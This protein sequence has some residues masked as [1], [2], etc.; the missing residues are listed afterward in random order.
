MSESKRSTHA[1]IYAREMILEALEDR[2]VLD[3]AVDRNADDYA[4]AVLVSDQ[5]L[6]QGQGEVVAVLEDYCDGNW[7]FVNG[8]WFA[9][10]NGFNLWYYD[11]LHYY[12]QDAATSRWLW[13]D[14][15]ID[16][17]WEY[18]QTWEYDSA[19][20]YWYYNDW[21]G[22]YYHQN[23]AH[24]YYHDHITGIWWQYNAYTGA[25]NPDATTQFAYGQETQYWSNGDTDLHCWLTNDGTTLLDWWIFNAGS[26][27]QWSGGALNVVLVDYTDFF[28]CVEQYTKTDVIVIEY[29][30]TNDGFA[31]VVD[32]LRILSDYYDTQ[33]SNLAVMS[34]GNSTGMYFGEWISS[35]NYNNYYNDFLELNAYMVDN[36]QI[37]LYHCQVG[38]ASTMLGK[39][40]VWTSTDVFANLGDQWYYWTWYSSPYEETDGIWN[41]N[42]YQVHLGEY[43]FEYRS[44]RYATY[45]MLFNFA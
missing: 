22:T 39:I 35:S 20:A 4:D 2:I 12:A 18:Y 1:S 33:I 42:Y 31:T 5:A 24:R 25:W 43:L 10:Q 28:E 32:G 17:Q 9:Y 3:G 23:D 16:N 7:H 37:M 21:N 40:A 6:D 11:S 44:D 26:D 8:W 14:A 15:V 38:A 41:H 36:G 13:F 34:H 19:I 30:L 29:D 27:G 45:N